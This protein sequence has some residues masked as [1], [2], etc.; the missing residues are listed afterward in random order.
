MSTHENL[1]APPARH[2]AAGEDGSTAG[3]TAGATEEQPRPSGGRG[4]T[5]ALVGGLLAIVAVGAGGAPWSS[6]R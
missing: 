4:R 3:P 5:V 1:F 2:A 6:T